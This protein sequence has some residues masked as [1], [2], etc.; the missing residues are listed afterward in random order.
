MVA[1][2]GFDIGGAWDAGAE[3]CCSGFGS[4][5]WISGRE[6]GDEDILMRDWEEGL[7]ERSVGMTGRLSKIL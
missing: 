4:G 3:G 2:F 7:K 1:V 5:F 6:E